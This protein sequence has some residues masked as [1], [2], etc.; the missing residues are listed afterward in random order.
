MNRDV[1]FSRKSD[2][3]PTPEELYAQ[4][5]EEFGFTLD[6]ASTDEN[7]KTEKYYTAVENGLKQDWG[8]ERVFLN[9]P[10]S[11]VADWVK[12]AWEESTKP[13]TLVVLLLPARTD[14]KYFHGYIQHRSEVRFLRGRL[15]FGDSTGNAP[16]PS[17]IVIYRAGGIL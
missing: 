10:Y 13:N 14:T 7:H 9:P 5:N 8:G 11:Q 16:F 6:P 1:L 17:M 2:E 4:L 3:W 12:K 15:K